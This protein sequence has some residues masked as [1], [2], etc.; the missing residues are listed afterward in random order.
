MAKKTLTDQQQD[1]MLAEINVKLTAILTEVKKT[2]GRVTAIETWKS[3]VQ[4]AYSA[5]VVVSTVVAFIGGILISHY[6][7]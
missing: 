4:G 2:N 5:I 1:V 6:W 7:K 3:K